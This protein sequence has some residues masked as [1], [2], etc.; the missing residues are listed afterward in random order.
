MKD[1]VTEHAR[2]VVDG[3]VISDINNEHNNGLDYKIENK[4]YLKD[5][6]NHEIV[7]SPNINLDYYNDL[8][9]KI[10]IKVIVKNGNIYINTDSKSKIEVIDSF[11]KRS[12]P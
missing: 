3:K 7:K 1:R 9:E 5:F 6:K 4:I 11:A 8:E 12:E 2:A 10:N